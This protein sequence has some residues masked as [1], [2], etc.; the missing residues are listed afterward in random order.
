MNFKKT[1]RKNLVNIPG[2]RTK[3]KI[4]VIESDDWGSIR[5]PSLQVYNLLLSR[6]IP[7]DNLYFLKYDA[8]ESEQDLVALF[9]V[10]SSFKDCRGNFPVVTANAVVANPDFE[11]ISASGRLEYHYE[12]ITDTYK[13]YPNHARSF[14]L[15][16]NEGIENKLLWPQFHG[17]EHLNVKKW[18][19]AINSGDP[20]ESAGFENNVILGMGR[21]GSSSRT[22]NYM[23]A[24]EYSTEDEFKELNSIA[25]DG[26]NIFSDL[27]GFPSKSFVAPCSIRGD[28]LDDSLKSG[29]VLYHQCG[30]QFIP[31]HTGGL[32]IKNR[33]WGQRNSIGQT[34]WRR[35]AT[36]EPSRNQNFDWISSCLAEINI[37]FRWGKPAVINSHRVNYMGSISLENRDNS[38][39]S[40]KQLLH[41]I[42]I[43]WPDVEFMTSDTLGDL[44]TNRSG[45]H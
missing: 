25:I 41:S 19:N 16:K 3:R 1:I 15:W 37:A 23:A 11:R 34:Y 14:E 24:F 31:N 4:V 40:L 12:L 29:G 36:F 39:R 21:D 32:K 43:K 8:L 38:L 5:M 13:H 28:H 30:Q 18:M 7:V 6:G 20:W 2:W 9:E 22:L 45:N 42:I 17:R 33:F 35:N 26:L 10:L 44:I 27:F